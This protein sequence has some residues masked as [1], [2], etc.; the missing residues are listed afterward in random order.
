MPLEPLIDKQD[1]ALL[2]GRAPGP[3]NYRLPTLNTP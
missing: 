3:I 1:R 2:D